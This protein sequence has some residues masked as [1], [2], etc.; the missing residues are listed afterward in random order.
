MPSRDPSA[1]RAPRLGP[2]RIRFAVIAAV[3]LVSLSATS[4]TGHLLN[5]WYASTVTI[6]TGVTTQDRRYV[7]D[8]FW[9]Y[10]NLT[11]NQAN[12]DR[13]RHMSGVHARFYTADSR[14]LSGNVNANCRFFTTFP[15]PVY[16]RDDDDFPGDGKNQEAEVTAWEVAWPATGALYRANLQFSHSDETVGEYDPDSGQIGFTGA[17][18]YDTGNPAERFNTDPNY[19]TKS[20][21]QDPYPFK[22]KGANFAAGT[23]GQAASS[24][25]D[26]A[27]ATGSAVGVYALRGAAD[28]GQKFVVPDL[29]R[30]LPAY[31][32]RARR[33]AVGV[34]TRGEARAVVTFAR[35]LTPADLDDLSALGLDLLT[36]EAVSH[37]ADGQRWTFGSPY[38]S[39]VY[40]S[41][42]EMAS[43]VDASLLGVVSAEARIGDRATLIRV[44][45]DRR[46]FLV[47]LAVE[48][49]QRS[50]P[51]E[52]D[53]V[54]N[55]LYWTLAGWS[56]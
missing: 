48:H 50:H 33:M 34:A 10:H 21:G 11:W 53:L 29:G 28:P 45:G 37:P 52:R 6:D 36:V 14:D 15:H 31:A 38:D 16:D 47:D 24:V 54:M 49:A 44:Q 19:L 56:D 7:D 4:V 1:S 23:C 18:S 35:P 20:Y 46:V 42:E 9:T 51:R 43:G 22:A 25:E 32:E 12:R 55:D 8:S 13:M 2:R 40:A 17:L 39:A 26:P 3:V 5:P 41:L 27:P 30:G